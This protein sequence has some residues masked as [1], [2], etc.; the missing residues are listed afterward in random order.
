MKIDTCFENFPGAI[1]KAVAASIPKCRPR[2]DFR[3]PIPAGIQEEIR[4]KKRLRSRWQ[5]TGD[6]ALRPEVNR[7]KRS[8]TRQLNEWRNG[9]WSA[10]LENLDPEDQKLWRMTKRVMRVPTASPPGHPEGIILSDSELSLTLWRPS[11][12][13]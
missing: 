9:Q 5:V 2:A 4:L 7:L 10:T 11:F 8:L 6:P 12:S 13:R 3:P 1:L